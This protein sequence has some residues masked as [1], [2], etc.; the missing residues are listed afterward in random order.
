[1][2]IAAIDIRN[3][4][5]GRNNRF[6][7]RV[8]VGVVLAK[9]GIVERG[10]GEINLPGV[11]AVKLADIHRESF[12]LVAGVRR[13]VAGVV[14]LQIGIGGAGFGLGTDRVIDIAKSADQLSL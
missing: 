4:R 13:A 14:A 12:W 7:R 11:V 6:E 1:M 2:R 8:A 10:E 5:F 9:G 3:Q